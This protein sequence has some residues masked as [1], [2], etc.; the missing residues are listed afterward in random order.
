MPICKN[1]EHKN[2]TGKEPSPKG[3]GFCASGEK[4]STIMKG[5]DGFLWIKK[6]GKWTKYNDNEIIQ[7]VL[8]KKLYK[9]WQNLSNGCIIVIYKNGIHSLVKSDMK[10]K[11]AKNKEILEQWNQMDKNNNVEAIIWSAISGDI[12]EQFIMYLIKNTTK[13]EI[14]EMLKMK[15]LPL[16][17]LQNYKKYF[18]RNEYISKKDYTLKQKI[19]FN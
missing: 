10:T 19:N 16:F 11:T 18:M 8:H 4:E 15:D 9:W 2:Y 5:K 3:L 12:I 1:N 13:K 14:D 7:K 17:L 6:H